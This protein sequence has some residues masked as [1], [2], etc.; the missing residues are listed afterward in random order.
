VDKQHIVAEIRRTAE[1]NGGKALG[2]LRFAAETG[3]R[4]NE[5]R[6][7]YWA[8][9]N[10]ALAEAGYPPNALQGRYEDD[11]MLNALASEVRRRGGMPTTSELSLRRREDSN[12]PS[13][14]VFDRLGP[15]ATWAAKVAAWC[16]ERPDYADVL[17][18]IEPLLLAE[19]HAAAPEVADDTRMKFGFVYLLKSGR[20]YKIG[21]THTQ[22]VV[23][24]TTS[25]SSFQ[26]R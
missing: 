13:A 6:G 2:R 12:F 9:W 8:R 19:Q 25:Q 10:E 17:A 3:I 11:Y 14:K 5:W 20:F 1:E 4:E 18:I 22:R 23:A 24:P 21:H 16:R 7:R 26:S 15:K